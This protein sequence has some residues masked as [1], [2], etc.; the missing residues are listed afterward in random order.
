MD[1]N[2]RQSLISVK[3]VVSRV[4]FRGWKFHVGTLGDG[5]YVQVQFEGPD[6]DT[7]ET[8]LIKGAKHYVSSYCIDDEIV[9]RCWVAVEAALKHEAMEE[10]KLDGVAPFHPH[11]DV[12][13][14]ADPNFPKVHRVQLNPKK[15]GA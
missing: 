1:D 6:T 15:V 13:A 5:Y 4:S 3:A 10:F 14:L 12:F 8:M 11:N 7:G 2:R 9:K